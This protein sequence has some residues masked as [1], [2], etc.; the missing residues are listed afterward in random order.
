MAATVERILEDALALTDDA[1]LLLAERLVESVNAS[2]NP[3]IE[4]RQLAEV[5][6]RMADVSDGRVKLVPREAALREVREAVQRTR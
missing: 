6:R 4:A 5:R 1:R 3:E 2:A